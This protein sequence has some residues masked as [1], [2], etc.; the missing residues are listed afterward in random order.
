MP[1]DRQATEKKFPRRTASTMCS[2]LPQVNRDALNSLG[3][4][5]KPQTMSIPKRV[6]KE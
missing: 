3:D 6:K 1:A 4:L 2:A 5:V